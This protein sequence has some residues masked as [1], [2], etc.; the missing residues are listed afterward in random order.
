M[1]CAAPG[2]TYV[3][4]HAVTQ[5]DPPHRDPPPS[6]PSAIGTLR[7]V[8]VLLTSGAGE[9]LHQLVGHAPLPDALHQG[10][11]VPEAVDG[12]E[13]QQ[14]LAV[15]LQG[16][17]LEVPVPMTTQVRRLNGQELNLHML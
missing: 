13:L 4:T 14:R 12:G 3:C 7:P 2:R 5:G 9:H 16:H 1:K 6:G 17:L 11:D 15:P 8:Q 10:L